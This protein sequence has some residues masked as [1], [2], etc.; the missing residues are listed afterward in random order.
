MWDAC[1][2][3]DVATVR[4]KKQPRI[5]N[6]Q[7][8]MAMVAHGHMPK[9]KVGAARMGARIARQMLPFEKKRRPAETARAKT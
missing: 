9:D 6:M 3:A 1:A 2:A 4:L 8:G 7:F 5:D